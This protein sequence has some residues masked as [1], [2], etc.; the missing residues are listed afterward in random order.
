[1]TAAFLVD[2]Y[3]LRTVALGAVALGAVGGALGTF[4]VLRRQALVGDAISHAAL[5][6][7]VLAYVL[8]GTKASLGL[9]LGAA[10]TGFAAT[11]AVGGVVRTT[12]VKSDAAL[13]IVLSVFFG[14]GLVLLTW[15]QR[16]PDA[17]QAGLDRFLF[18]QAATILRDDVV[19]IAVAGALALAVVAILWKQLKLLAFD[20]EFGASLG[21]RMH[22]VEIALTALLVVAIVIGLQMVGAVLMSA[23]IVAP[24]AAARQ[25]TNRLGPMTI[26]AAGVGAAAGAAGAVAS[27]EVERLPTGPT[28]V[29]V[30]TLIVVASLL[31]A[32]RGVLVRR[33]QARR[34]RSRLGAHVVLTDL[35]VLEEGH[36][37]V[38]RGHPAATIGV[39]AEADATTALQAL[40][41][42]GL[43]RRDP[44]GNWSLTERGRKEARRR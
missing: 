7:V 39:M 19:T 16:R 38:A 36:G 43:V 6:G 26:V 12:R 8:V 28:I 1:M 21:M 11:L 25:W 15:V 9:M 22:A 2:D 41:R 3:T 14:V 13:G 23:M 44:E 10:V 34:A 40:E 27:S 17:S 37:G 33:L 30:A 35:A 5:P 4:A 20:A 24:A 42:D 29:L 32:P 18:G 31:V